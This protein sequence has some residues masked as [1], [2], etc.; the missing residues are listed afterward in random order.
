MSSVP[1]T[2]L[3]TQRSVELWSGRSPAEKGQGRKD[4]HEESGARAPGDVCYSL[5]ECVLSDSL[6]SHGL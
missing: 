1:Q 3:H 5:R 4:C 2:S 6:R